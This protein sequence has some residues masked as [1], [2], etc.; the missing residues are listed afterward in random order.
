MQDAYG[1]DRNQ[2]PVDML[3]TVG[4]TPGPA[5]G[6]ATARPAIPYIFASAA[7]TFLG[8]GTPTV[9]MGEAVF[10]TLGTPATVH[11]PGKGAEAAHTVGAFT[12]KKIEPSRLQASFFF[13]REDRAR[14]P[15]MEAGLRRNLMDALSCRAGRQDHSQPT[16]HESERRA[17]G[18]N[19]RDNGGGVCRLP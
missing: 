7:H 6:P 12:S 15:G 4:V 9:P 13:T 3:R 1:L 8:I 2:F 18:R 14:V 11:A 16:G 19:G 17:N 10:N 5:D